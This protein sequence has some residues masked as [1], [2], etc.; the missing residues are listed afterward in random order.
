MKC[1]YSFILLALLSTASYSQTFF[2]KSEHTRIT[3]TVQEWLINNK[4]TL[5]Q[6][7]DDSTYIIDCER[8]KKGIWGPD[9]VYFTLKQKD[10]VIGQTKYQKFE[11]SLPKSYL[12]LAQS[13]LKTL[14][15]KVAKNKPLRVTLKDTTITI[16][17]PKKFPEIIR[18]SVVVENISDKTVTY[19]LSFEQDY[20]ELKF[21]NSAIADERKLTKDR[22]EESFEISL[23]ADTTIKDKREYRV[24]LFYKTS[25][26]HELQFGKLLKIIVLPEPAKPEG[27]FHKNELILFAGTTY[28]HFNP[29]N[30]VSGLSIEPML[31]I[32]MT[33][34][35]WA[36]FGVYIHPNF[37]RD[38]ASFRRTGYYR[39]DQQPLKFDTSFVAYFN[40][41]VD[42]GK[43]IQS[44]GFYSDIILVPRE[45]GS[46]F[47]KGIRVSPTFRLEFI[48]RTVSPFTT[49]NS[50]VADTLLYSSAAFKSNRRPIYD[51][52]PALSDRYTAKYV[53]NQLILAFSPMVEADVS[54]FYMYF[55]PM[56]GARYQYQKT[57]GAVGPDDVLHFRKTYGAKFGIRYK[58]IISLS[59][60]SRDFL[61]EDEYLNISF[62]IPITIADLTKK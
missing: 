28:D 46:R 22:S 49:T 19:K 38:T 62:G 44:I 14:L 39:L 59:I 2:V 47:Q 52:K 55:Q 29:T 36:R 35:V 23:A 4:F 27:T 21:R 40:D 10:T 12:E 26:E 53:Q 11:G 45:K 56:F 6:T 3:A 50:S 58:S 17:R 16:V 8:I 33:E 48:K 20:P 37:S 57:T 25:D 7:S 24:T 43:K 13:D 1:I 18:T 60:D 5:S 54:G 30:K 61:S 42:I 15:A 32:K 34:R 9:L 31:S 51:E 41:R